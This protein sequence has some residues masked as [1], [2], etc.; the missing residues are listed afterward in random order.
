MGANTSDQRPSRT[1]I[2][3]DFRITAAREVMQRTAVAGDG[4]GNALAQVYEL[5]HALGQL[6]SF[7]DEEARDRADLVDA[8]ARTLLGQL[9]RIEDGVA[10]VEQLL[11]REVE[12]LG[13]AIRS[14][15]ETGE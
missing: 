8:A 7:A 10:R 2:T 6:I 15:M 13:M 14:E 9:D 11:T 1:E 4:Y 5:R 3:E 12:V